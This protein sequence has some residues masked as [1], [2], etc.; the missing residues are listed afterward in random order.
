YIPIFFIYT[1]S[2]VSF[3]NYNPKRPRT[4]TYKVDSIK[5]DSIKVDSMKAD[6]IKVDSAARTEDLN[7]NQ[8]NQPNQRNPG[9]GQSPGL[10]EFAEEKLGVIMWPKL[11]DIFEAVQSGKRKILVRSC[12]GAGKTK[13][14]AA[15]C[16]WYFVTHPDSIVLTTASSWMQV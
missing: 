15:I 13:S 2:I 8:R 10:I 14:L 12:N 5:V 1:I 9:P 16:N 7:S 3:Q 6:S 4:K 11:V